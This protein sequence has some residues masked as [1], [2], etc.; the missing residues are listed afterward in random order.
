MKRNDSISR[1]TLRAAAACALLCGLPGT[2]PAQIRIATAI[3]YKLTDLNA[4]LTYGASNPSYAFA[5]SNSGQ[6]VGEFRNYRGSNL[7]FRTA[8]NMPIGEFDY[9]G[10][11]TGLT[12]SDSFSWAYAVNASGVA[13]GD[14]LGNLTGVSG[15]SHGFR[16]KPG[17][18]LENLNA[19]DYT[20]NPQTFDVISSATQV[21]PRGINDSGWI[22]GYYSTGPNDAYAE[23][24]QSFLSFGPGLTYPIDSWFGNHR[25]SATFDVN[26]KGQIVG[27]IDSTAYF[28]DLDSG[29]IRIGTLG[30]LT[31]VAYAVNDSGQVVGQADTAGGASHAFLFQ[32][33]IGQNGMHD[34]DT[35]NSINSGALSINNSGTA[36]GYFGGVYNLI[37]PGTRAAI[38]SNGKMTDLNKLVS[39]ATGSTVLCPDP[40]LT[41][42][43]G[44]WT[45]RAATGINDSGQIVGF[46]QNNIDNGE[47]R[48]FRL[49]PVAAFR[50]P[51]YLSSSNSVN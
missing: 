29:L 6:V 44:C 3:S 12:Y 13:V 34:L 32:K 41:Q 2:L 47:I 23:D 5:I 36:V 22:V 8:P 42:P 33:V 14:S 28:Y 9:L 38:F 39:A 4:G 15:Q 19:P 27:E 1:S 31:S 18:A 10:V 25:H 17:A 11:L 46:M 20:S 7:G 16:A 50:S 30:G 48:S 49:D 35:M 45:L 26:N 21:H 43:A 37:Y 51:W 40:S 24:S